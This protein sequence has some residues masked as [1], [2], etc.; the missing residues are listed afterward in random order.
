MA[1]E[2]NALMPALEAAAEPAPR[3]ANFLDRLKSNAEKLVRITPADAPPGNDPATVVARIRFAAAH[4]DVA[5]AAADADALPD[6]AKPLLAAWVKKA[7][8]REAALA[9]ARNVATGAVA[10]LGKS[11]AR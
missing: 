6:S 8:A 2:L 4:N 9:A 11:P 3:D 7:A 5:A 10:A 1:R